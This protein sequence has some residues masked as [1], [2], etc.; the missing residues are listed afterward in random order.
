M[1]RTQTVLISVTLFPGWVLFFSLIS[2]RKKNSNETTIR[3]HFSK[4]RA[5]DERDGVCHVMWCY[6]VTFC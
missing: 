1:H 2:D 3:E 4:V 6:M 5:S